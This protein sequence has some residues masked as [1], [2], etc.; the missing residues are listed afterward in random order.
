MRQFLKDHAVWL[1]ALA[2]LLLSSLSEA[3]FIGY[4]SPQTVQ[5]TLATNRFCTGALQTFAINNLGQTQH[6]LQVASISGATSF[7]AQFVGQ[8]GFGNTYPISDALMLS[9]GNVGSVRGTGYFPAIFVQVTCTPNTATYSASYS[10]AWATFD[11]SAASYLTA[12]TD[13]AVFSGLAEN[14]N[15]TASFPP[16][17]ASS[18]GQISFSYSAGGAGGTLVI[19]CTN[20]LFGGGSPAQVFSASLANTTSPQL[21][22]VPDLPCPSLT[23]TYN[24]NSTSGTI[25]TEYTFN[26]PGQNHIAYQYMHV[27]GTTATVA[28]ATYGVLHTLTVNTGGAGTISIFDLAS[29]SCTGTPATNTVAVITAVAATLQTFTYDVNLL[30][31]IC[32]KA[33]VAMDFTVSSQ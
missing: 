8:D 15:Q 13:K 31:G 30:N 5:Q 32:V 26:Q 22:Q 25:S 24:N 21:F 10:G 28:K 23:V 9:S 20:N 3:Q 33:S 1:F 4:V 17:F 12:Q 16:P 2:I 7:K 18:A 19:T 29:A 6:Y 14:A 27:T 11:V